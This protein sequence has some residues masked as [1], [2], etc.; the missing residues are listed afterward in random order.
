MVESEKL[1]EEGGGKFLWGKRR[2][3][4]KGRLSPHSESGVELEL[5]FSCLSL[6]VEEFDCGLVWISHLAL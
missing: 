3:K 2:M 5:L 1:K 6:E 4:R